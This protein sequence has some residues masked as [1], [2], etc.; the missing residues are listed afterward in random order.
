M[1]LISNLFALLIMNT[2]ENDDESVEIFGDNTCWFLKKRAD[3]WNFYQEAWSWNRTTQPFGIFQLF[4]S[5]TIRK[6]RK[7]KKS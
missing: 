3:G 1:Y 2:A 7:K 4:I 5:Q 6:K